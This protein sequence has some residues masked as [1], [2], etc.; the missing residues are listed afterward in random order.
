MAINNTILL[1]GG[2]GKTSSRIAQRL[3]Q[4][5]GSN[6]LVASRRG[7]SFIASSANDQAIA[8]T[9]GLITGVTFDWHDP[10]GWHTPFDPASNGNM[11]TISAIYLV[12]PPGT[13]SP[14]EIVKPF[15][16]LAIEKGVRRFVL[17]STSLIERGGPVHGEV[18]DYLGTLEEDRNASEGKG[19]EWAVVRPSWFFGALYSLG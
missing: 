4:E 8:H 18:H 12:L 5:K 6:V 17:M 19:I 14:L 7:T 10:S 3:S 13:S 1:T 15:I 16:D 11:T 9:K 2:L